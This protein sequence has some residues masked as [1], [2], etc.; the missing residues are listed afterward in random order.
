M[1]RRLARVPANP[2][3]SLPQYGWSPDRFSRYPVR[4]RTA[5]VD[6]RSPIVLSPALP[7]IGA[8]A[9]R[10]FPCPGKKQRITT[11]RRLELP[12]P[13]ADRLELNRTRKTR[14]NKKLYISRSNNLGRYRPVI[15]RCER[16]WRKE[17][18]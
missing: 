15:L 6:R 13:E 9:A 10:L 7:V 17:G 3:R 12:Q 11:L 16:S 8:D 2:G 1:S 5:P 14:T 4:Q 18:A